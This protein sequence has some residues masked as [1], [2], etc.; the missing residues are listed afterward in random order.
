[1]QITR[2]LKDP[3][4]RLLTL[5]GPGGIGKT[6]LAIEIAS[7]QSDIFADGVYFVPLQPLNSPDFM[8]TA[9]AEALNFQSYSGGELKD[10]LLNYL[11]VKN[12]LFVMDNL[13]HLL[14]GV[15]LLS[16]I[17]HFASH[18]KILATS[19]EA[20]KLREEWVFNVGG[21]SFPTGESDLEI[22]SY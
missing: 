17:L 14:E 20:L 18:T 7:L 8:I 11:Q 13:E 19:R 10:Q 16:D 4:C 9:I 5:V 1:A 6:R 12:I 2:L 3:A 22:E 21:L 15:A